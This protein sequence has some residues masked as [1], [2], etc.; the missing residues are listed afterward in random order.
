MKERTT[1]T[2]TIRKPRAEDIRGIVALI[3][4]CEPVLTAHISYIYWMLVRYSGETCA[5]AE[6]NGEI[7]GWCSMV[8]ASDERYFL[9]QLAVAR[10]VRRN[11]LAEALVEHLLEKLQAERKA[12]FQL[13]F[14]VDG[15]NRIVLDLAEVVAGNTGMH[16]LKRPEPVE[17]VEEGSN[18]VLYVLSKSERIS[19]IA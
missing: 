10:N 15:K 14:T 2:T 4:S 8:S 13:E 17:L 12:N 18:E 19:E 11:H 5:V 6:Q 16:I 7:V 3:R 1:I 9:H